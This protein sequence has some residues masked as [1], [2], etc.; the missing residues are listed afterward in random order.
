MELAQ[1]FIEMPEHEYFWAN[2]PKIFYLWGHSYEFNDNNNWEIFEKFATYVGN[3]TDIF[4]A[5]NAEIYDY[6]K[7]YDALQWG[8]NGDFVYNPSVIDIYLNY[9]G[10]HIVLK[11]GKLTN[12]E[13]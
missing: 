2:E 13:N 12:L 11:A 1:K 10:R 6:V 8:I 9:Y 5:T 3:R 7:A 4:Y